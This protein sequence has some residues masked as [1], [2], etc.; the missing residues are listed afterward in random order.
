MKYVM[1]FREILPILT[2]PANAKRLCESARLDR[3]SGYNHN[4]RFGRG[5]ARPKWF[6]Q[7]FCLAARHF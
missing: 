6:L 5:W 1:G 4:Y 7:Y 3:D 2:F